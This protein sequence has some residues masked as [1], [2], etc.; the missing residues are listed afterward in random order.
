MGRRRQFDEREALGTALSVF[1]QKGYEGASIEDLTKAT[2]VARPGL[3]AAFGNKERLFRKALDLYEAQLPLSSW[4]FR[5]AWRCKPRQA[6]RKSPR[7]LGRG[8]RRH[9]AFTSRKVM[10]RRRH[11]A[12]PAAKQRLDD[13]QPLRHAR[14]TI[15]QTPEFVRVFIL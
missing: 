12:R 6:H 2:G 9:V 8:C 7:T 14:F 10:T 5:R 4:R 1:W 15:P 13:P 3:Y 11:L